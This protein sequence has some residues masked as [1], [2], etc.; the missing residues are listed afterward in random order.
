M[1]DYRSIK[2]KVPTLNLDGTT[3]ASPVE[4]EMWYDSGKFYQ[5]L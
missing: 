4:G 5:I 1:T 2:Y 3:E